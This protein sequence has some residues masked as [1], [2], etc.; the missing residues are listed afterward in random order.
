[1]LFGFQVRNISNNTTGN[2]CICYNNVQKYHF[3]NTVKKKKEKLQSDVVEMM[4]QKYPKL[5]AAE[6]VLPAL[7]GE[8]S[9]LQGLLLSCCLIFLLFSPDVFFFLL[10]L[11]IVSHEENVL[12]AKSLSFMLFICIMGNQ[13]S[14]SA[15]KTQRCFPPSFF[16]LCTE[17]GA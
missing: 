14:V 15:V 17:F 7:G 4:V 2:I 3:R 12:D 11:L 9:I 13:G 5:S 8:G 1:M 10:L 6:R 16:F